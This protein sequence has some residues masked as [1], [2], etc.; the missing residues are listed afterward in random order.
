MVA[1][2]N[3]HLWGFIRYA[4]ANP[5]SCLNSVHWD[6]I[7]AMAALYAPVNLTGGGTATGT[8]PGTYDTSTDIPG[9]TTAN[10]DTTGI[11]FE[12]PSSALTDQAMYP[13]THIFT[14]VPAN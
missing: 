5:N 3:E 6:E 12:T 1:T 14:A 9:K 8:D 10:A 13:G 11:G 7:K 2:G 4:Q